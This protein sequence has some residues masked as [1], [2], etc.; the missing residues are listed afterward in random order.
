MVAVPSALY[1]A[2]TI[3]TE[4]VIP[5][6]YTTE[7]L[8]DEVSD[9]SAYADSADAI[10]FRL[11]ENVDVSALDYVLIE[12]GLGSYYFTSHTPEAL[13]SMSFKNSDYRLF[14]IGEDEFLEFVALQKLSLSGNT[15]SDN[16][17][18]ISGEKS[19][20]IT[21][22]NNDTVTF[23][24]NTVSAGE[25]KSKSYGGAICGGASST[26]TLSNNGTVTFSGNTV[27]ASGYK[28]KS[29]G[30]AIY[31]GS[32]S[33]I[34]LNNNGTVTFSGN[35]VSA[36][37]YYSEPYGGAI[38]G[39]TSSTITLS[40]N[41][42]VFFRGN[43]ASGSKY[44]RGGAIY[45]GDS[46]TITLN[47][48]GMVIFSGN[49]A[50]YHN[51]RAFGGAIYGGD[52]STI[53]L[54]NNGTVSFS[55]NT[56][57]STQLSSD[58]VIS[59][60]AIYGGSSSTI[61][62]SNNDTVTFTGNTA[63][64]SSHVGGSAIS[65]DT[66]T[67]SDNGMVS[68][69]GNTASR[70]G[71][72]IEGSTI[73]LS[74]N[75]TV[76]FS[77]NNGGAISG[78]SSGA[79]TLSNNGTVSFIDNNGGAISG[80]TITLSNN[81]SVTFRGN[82][83]SFSG[84]AID[85]NSYRFCTITLS[86]NGTVSFIG[87]TLSSESYGHSGGAIFGSTITLSD[88]GTVSFIGN[89]VSSESYDA[90]G[91]AI[92]GSTITLSDNGEV[93]FSG[94]TVVGN[95]QVFGGAIY[96][97]S[98]STI[99]LSNNGTVS[100]IGNTAS[101]S[102][103]VQGGAIYGYTIMLSNNGTVTFRGNTASSS[104]GAIYSYGN[105]HIRN[106]DSVEF[107]GNVEKSDSSYRL[108]SIYV[109]GGSGNTVSLSAAA[110]KSIIFRDS[111]YIGSGTTVDFN[112]DYTDAEGNI[113]AQKGDILFTG[114]TTEA[115]LLAAKGSAGTAAEVLNSRTTEVR[116]MTNLYGGRLRV[117]DGAVY[118]GRGI[119]VH[120]G[121]EATVRVKDATLNHA[122][123]ELLFNR[124]TKLEVEG[125]SSISGSIVLRGY[126]VSGDLELEGGITI[127]PG[128]GGIII[129][130]GQ[131]GELGDGT[132][133][134]G[135]SLTPQARGDLAGSSITLTPA[136]EMS[137][138]GSVTLD[139]GLSISSGS[140]PAT[141]RGVTLADGSITGTGTLTCAVK[142]AS[143]QGTGASH[144]LKGVKLE[145]VQ[146]ASSL[147]L[148]ELTD[149]EFDDACMF[150]VGA[151]GTIVLNDALLCVTLPELGTGNEGVLYLDCT[152][153][154]HC[155]VEGD[156]KLSL[157]TAA[158]RA[159]GYSGLQLDFGSD[160]NYETLTLNMNG[161]TYTGN[162]GSMATFD[163]VPEPATTTL[164]LLA[165]AALASRRRRA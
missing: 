129:D 108:R 159:A 131:E 50:S 57:S 77:D 158:V 89:T 96:G 106:N 45:G 148:L 112:A 121:S 11:I 94:N 86:D 73:T 155:T 30:G 116:A 113:L 4:I 132:F 33:T 70:G 115:D 64:G 128:P 49:T 82:T 90:S 164:S 157:D 120:E 31:G 37:D 114:A 2:Y 103:Y 56:A 18:A 84:G 74:N 153:L 78:S 143:I 21:L 8:V 136:A 63:S 40:N 35:T 118:Q 130:P 1:A 39:D 72:A 102:S 32:S 151:E 93:E 41:G 99:T 125:N 104:G 24:G 161:A 137:V 144:T 100:F 67:L 19:S 135:A 23:N 22:S 36:G 83:A 97:G 71:G 107:A 88:N 154:F 44:I 42:T 150:S 47:N 91:G 145:N 98:S 92:S 101:G 119:T 126:T 60:G 160:A 105:L 122:G 146:F 48:N 27:S 68:F 165:L 111:M 5:E 66:I 61:M 140:T 7:I 28:S 162:V 69:I 149:V 65:G 29:Y 51:Q 75:G 141:L 85:G 58:V 123:Y 76:S 110:G 46:S 133:L 6:L 12:P 26:I 59:G 156:L 16:G 134:P 81:D 147:T 14:N 124:G 127:N 95:S 87:N 20:T 53:T 80:Y 139:G 10:A 34:T 54:S 142:N 9:I 163:V 152:Q 15:A 13:K 117:E 138:K 109:S 62:L 52:Y 55:E 43:A 38:F 79:I 17:A 3:P 25:Y